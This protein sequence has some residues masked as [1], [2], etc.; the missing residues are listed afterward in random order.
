MRVTLLVVSLSLLYATFLLHFKLTLK[1]SK[2]CP[3]LRSFAT[4]S[5]LPESLE[6]QTPLAQGIFIRKQVPTLPMVFQA[7][8]PL[9]NLGS[10]VKRGRELAPL[11]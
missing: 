5:F 3:L 11:Q 8:P 4:S 9:S 7:T 10:K 1:Q 6:L 2:L